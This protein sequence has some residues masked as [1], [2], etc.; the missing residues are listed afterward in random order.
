MK[1]NGGSQL[2]D[3][4]MLVRHALIPALTLVPYREELRIRYAAWLQ[5]RNAEQT[6]TPE[7]REWLDRMAEHIANSL[8]IEPDDF[9]MGWFAQHGSIGK[10]HAL[11][12][13]QLPQLLA[14]MNERL[15]A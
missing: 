7:Q 4:V 6:F 11:F 1:G 13:A 12:G 14:E 15:V 2:A 3:L 10:A 5:E 9:E 8:S